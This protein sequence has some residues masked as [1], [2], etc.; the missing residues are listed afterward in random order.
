MS[1]RIKVRVP[2]VKM[3][4][5]IVLNVLADYRTRERNWKH[6]TQKEEIEL[7]FVIFRWYGYI[8]GL[9]ACFCESTGKLLWTITKFSK[10]AEYQ[11]IV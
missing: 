6:E 10:I 4:V 8:L 9:Y 3:F 2:R 11:F 1:E 7:M 5:N